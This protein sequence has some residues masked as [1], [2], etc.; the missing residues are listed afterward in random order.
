MN[1]R[2]RA[3]AVQAGARV[4]AQ[5]L[6][7]IPPQRRESIGLWDNNVEKFA[8]LI[9][10]ECADIIE[11]KQK[12]WCTTHGISEHYFQGVQDGLDLSI[13]TIKEHFGVEE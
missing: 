6:T 12:E 10:R 11:Q 7:S 4:S 2:I 5:T 3:L 8:E 1:E 13:G 9:V